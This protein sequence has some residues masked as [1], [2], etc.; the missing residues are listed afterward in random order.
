METATITT[1]MIKV[2]TK[3]MIMA[4][5]PRAL[6]RIMSWL[7][8]SFP[9]GGFAYS[10]GLEAAFEQGAVTD[11][12]TLGEWLDG[13]IGFGSARND[14]V[15]LSVAHQ[16][17]MSEDHEALREV[18]DLAR[19]LFGAPE[20]KGESIVQG[21]AFW[22]TVRAAWAHAGLDDLRPCLPDGE[23]AY[24]IAIGIAA[25]LHG[26][27]RH[28]ATAAFLHGFAANGVSAAI[29]LGM[30]GQTDGQRVVQS[31]EDTTIKTADT[32]E[33]ATIQDI[34]SASLAIDM[35]A[36]AHETQT[37]RLFRS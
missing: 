10:H 4:T 7:S 15:L 18:A 11:A 20:L 2:T 24:P 3:A 33:D 28:D 13:A 23:I 17:A 6:L 16:A 32:C 9:V 25:A 8:P 19:C 21:N 36:L 27:G 1:G 12:T 34:G 31:L 35:M 37:T 22:R 26:V 30:I 29:R 5:D 14:A